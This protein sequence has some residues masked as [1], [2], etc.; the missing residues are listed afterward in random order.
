M[1]E[2]A[3]EERTIKM[4]C[5]PEMT[6][7]HLRCDAK[8]EQDMGNRHTHRYMT[9]A[10]ICQVM[11]H[12]RLF[13]DFGR[14][15]RIH[16]SAVRNAFA[17][18]FYAIF[19]MYLKFNPFVPPKKGFQNIAGSLFLE[20][21]SKKPTRG[22]NRRL[23]PRK[24]SDRSRKFLRMRRNLRKKRKE[25]AKFLGGMVRNNGFVTQ[26]YPIFKGYL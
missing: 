19:N 18:I 16:C 8:C 11:I 10:Y 2:K 13:V 5:W 21:G 22:T 3:R 1:V 9:Y 23:V 15:T 26:I 25:S 7:W 4:K 12:D 24:K 14:E 17:P 20:A 6:P